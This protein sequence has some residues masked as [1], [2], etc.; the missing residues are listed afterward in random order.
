VKALRDD[1]SIVIDF[2]L[3][4][5]TVGVPGSPNIAQTILRKIDKSDIVVC[6]VS[7]ITQNM[8]IGRLSP[9]PNVLIELGYAL[10]ALGA[11]RIV[12][13]QNT[14]Y[15]GPELLPFDL[16]MN[17]VTT[18]EM[19]AR[20][21]DRASE[22]GKLQKKLERAIR[23]ILPT[24]EI[25]SQEESETLSDVTDEAIRSIE[26]SAPNK[27]IRVGR[28]VE[29]LNEELDSLAPDFSEGDARDELFIQSINTTQGFVFEYARLAKTIAVMG[30]RDAVLALYR[31]FE[32]IMDN[33]RPPAG[34][35]GNFYRSDFDYYKFLGHELFI[36]L[37]SSLISENQ[38]I[39]ITNLLNKDI[40]IKNSL[41]GPRLV[42][43]SAIS[44]PVES[45]EI[46]SNRLN[47]KRVSFH[48]DTLNQRYT[49]GTLAEIVPIEEFTAADFFL[50]LRS[51]KWRPWSILYIG[52]GEPRYLTEST[53]TQF[54]ENLL[55]PL[56]LKSQ[57]EFRQRIVACR[58]SL[59]RFYASKTPFFD[60]LED[61]DVSRV[62]SR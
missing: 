43:F 34:F 10:K 56:D 4:R 22:R 54:A 2:V 5:D 37:I 58:E 62:G 8:S 46:H 35:N 24:L 49:D 21:T 33:Y 12:M 40:Y 61:F 6:D 38:W 28:F 30:D 18:Y 47:M 45:F 44:E 14:E 42:D 31:I 50:R 60:T 20:E 53:S 23:T 36:V 9:N 11:D 27:T 32:R 59:S 57:D 29:L 3:E 1:D 25:A 17:R 26:N 16:K 41:S 39:M 15:G 52:H 48:A 55:A 51:E 7:I 19:N 13:V